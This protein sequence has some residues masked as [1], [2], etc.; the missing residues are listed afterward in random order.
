MIFPLIG[1]LLGLLLGIFRAWQNGGK[2][3]DLVQWALV[4]AIVGGLLGLF[5]LIIIERSLR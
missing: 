3:L 1:I 5:V 2:R 4:F